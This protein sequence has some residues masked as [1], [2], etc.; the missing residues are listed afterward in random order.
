MNN[1]EDRLQSA[2]DAARNAA[3]GMPTAEQQA[4][5]RAQFLTQVQGFEAGV[6]SNGDMRH[7]DQTGALSVSETV[8]GERRMKRFYTTRRARLIAA[9]L[10]GLI[11]AGGFWGASPSLRALAQ[12]V[13]ELFERGSSD[14]QPS[15]VFVGPEPPEPENPYPLSMDEVIAKT[16]FNLR[17]PTFIPER[18]QFEG[19]R[20]LIGGSGVE[21]FYNCEPPYS[22]IITEIATSDP[23]TPTEVGASAVIEDVP[24]RD[25]IGQY[26]RG[27]WRT[28]VDRALLPTPGGEPVDAREI[29][30][31]R[32]WSNEENWHQ[33]FWYEDGISFMVITGGGILGNDTPNP[34][35]LTKEDF[36]ALALGMEAR[37]PAE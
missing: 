15:S 31:T 11:L 13:I 17:V 19:A 35:A 18:Y 16:A 36:V 8:Q 6:S 29:P 23:F 10:L 2:F 14:S 3:Q 4:R 12:T 9:I 7:R 33:L 20:S 22:V 34:C 25:V 32:V 28:E 5:V 24:I 1:P 27:A 37:Y 21:L 30:A 26:V